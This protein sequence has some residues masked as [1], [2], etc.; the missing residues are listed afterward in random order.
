MMEIKNYIESYFEEIFE[1]IHKTI[2]E[3]YPTETV[4]AIWKW[5]KIS[6][7]KINEYT[8]SPNREVKSRQ[9]GK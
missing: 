5:L 2:N 3:I 4:C 6:A 9:I 1:V 7:K 8:I